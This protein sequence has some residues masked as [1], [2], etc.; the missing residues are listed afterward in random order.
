[1]KN[2]GKKSDLH[3]YSVL[4]SSSRNIMAPRG[5]SVTIHTPWDLLAAD[6]ARP[7]KNV[8]KRRDNS[9]VEIAALL[10]GL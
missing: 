3:L 4:Q 5:L 9:L 10:T 2:M 6:V 7:G 1:M 8:V